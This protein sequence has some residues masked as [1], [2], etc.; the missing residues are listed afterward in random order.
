MNKTILTFVSIAA[1]AM[2]GG[3]AEKKSC[4]N[5]KPAPVE[6]PAP[7]PVVEAPAPAPAP[8]VEAPAP[9][10][11]PAPIVDEKTRAVQ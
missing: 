4:C 8:V 6:K 5:P 7:A 2:L 10:E 3:C 11:E 9:V 1:L